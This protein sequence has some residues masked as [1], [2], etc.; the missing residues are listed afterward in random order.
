MGK[1]SDFERKERDYYP[2]PM[3]AVVPLLPH[4]IVATAAR[5][6]K[7]KFIEPCAGDGRL[8]RHI[9]SDGHKC[10]Y[11]CDIEPQ[12]EGIETRDVLFFDAPLPDCDLIITNPPWER[13]VLHAMID[14]FVAHADTWL[15]FDA[16]WM[17]TVQAMPYR[18]L[19]AKIVSIG[20]VSW[21][22]N[23]VSGMDNCCW[24]LFSKNHRGPTK[25]VFRSLT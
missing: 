9:E 5:G 6:Y 12:A 17:H 3:E 2:T 15:L 13:E 10:V 16:D 19:V 22:G 14:R 18:H 11:A 20:R 24:Y 21:E 25:F 4:I 8:I 7:A 23:G 1:R